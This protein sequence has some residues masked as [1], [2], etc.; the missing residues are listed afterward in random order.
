MISFWRS[1]EVIRSSL[2]DLPQDAPILP[3][4]ALSEIDVRRLST[5][6]S[7]IKAGRPDVINDC[8]VV[9]K[10][11]FLRDFPAQ[12]FLQEPALVEVNR[13][14]IDPQEYLRNC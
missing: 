10:G 7:I 13:F 12:T 8:C 1:N 2:A 14:Y 9:F 5:L 6:V 3:C 11:D 4:V